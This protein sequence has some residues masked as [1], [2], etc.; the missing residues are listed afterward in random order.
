MIQSLIKAIKLSLAGSTDEFSADDILDW[1]IPLSSSISQPPLIAIYQGKLKYNPDS[2][3]LSESQPRLYKVRQTID[4][5]PSQ[6]EEEY[7]LNNTPLEG[8][9][10]ANLL[11]DTDTQ[12]GRHIKPIEQTDLIID[13]KKPAISFKTKFEFP[14]RVYLDYS[15][16]GVLTTKEFQQELFIDFYDT[17]IAKVEKL[18]ALTTGVVLTNY[19]DLIQ[20]SNEGA[21]NRYPSDP[22]SVIPR[23]EGV[24]TLEAIP[25]IQENLCRL[26]LKLQ[27]SGTLQIV[28]EIVDDLD[29][30]KS[31]K[32]SGTAPE[33]GGFRIRIQK[34]HDTKW[35][36]VYKKKKT[37]EAT[38]ISPI[39]TKKQKRSSKKKR[40]TTKSK[41][42]I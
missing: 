34:N 33:Q 26:Q 16:V 7:T 22:V 31:I 14:G 25:E 38:E 3:D 29:F 12:D 24:D 2:R 20:T 10:E 41:K 5:E 39:A 40:Q 37:T 6:S 17:D 9:V 32:S 4:V 13:Y 35:T 27:V 30:I 19:D 1:P 11:S 18:N 36:P 28:K 15:Y 21:Q 42:R 8:T 23:I